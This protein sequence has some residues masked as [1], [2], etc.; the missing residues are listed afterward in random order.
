MDFVE[1]YINQRRKINYF[2]NL[3]GNWKKHSMQLRPEKN[4]NFSFDKCEFFID[5]LFNMCRISIL[6]TRNEVRQQIEFI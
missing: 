5:S 4:W 3:A 1:I 6:K 2:I